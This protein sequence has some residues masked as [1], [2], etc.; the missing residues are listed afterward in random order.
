M[1][2]GPEGPGTTQ[3]FGRLHEC[4]VGEG[5]LWE[6]ILKNRNN[7]EKGRILV[8]FKIVTER[9]KRSVVVEYY[10]F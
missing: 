2:T 7:M 9:S 6:V 8:S 5:R 4:L 1:A 10:I 3:G